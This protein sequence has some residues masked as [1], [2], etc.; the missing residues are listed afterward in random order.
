M[1]DIQLFISVFKDTVIPNESFLLPVSAGAALYEQNEPLCALC[2]HT[3]D[4]ISLRNPQYCELTVQYWAWKNRSFD[5]GGLLHQRRYFDFSDLHPFACDQP[6]KSKRPYTVLH[7][8]DSHSM[9]RLCI[10][11]DSIS[12]LTERYRFI[13]PLSE[14][15]YQSVES[16][17][18]RHDR[19]SFDDLGLLRRIIRQRCP[20][21]LDSAE[22]YLRQNNAYFCNMFI[23]DKALFDDYS[24]WLFGILEDYTGQKP[25]QQQYPREQGKIAER[26]FGI[27]MTHLKQYSTIPWAELPRAHFSSVNGV[28]VHNRSF[29]KFWY[30]LCPPGSVR[31]G[32]LRKWL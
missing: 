9:H 8:P 2:D 10:T 28:T 21:Y 23:A 24:Q 17:Y 4:N 15:I 31:R 19:Q 26:L 14:N 1:K 7:A 32:F 29:S 3:G 22:A 13:A 6:K 25:L 12:A 20:E 27:Y 30:T 18:N 11:Q 5:V 16:Y